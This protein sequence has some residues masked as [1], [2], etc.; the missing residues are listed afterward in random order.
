MRDRVATHLAVRRFAD[1]LRMPWHA[2]T[3]AVLA[4]DGRV[5]IEY[6]A[7]FDD[8][9]VIGVDEHAWRDTRNGDECV[10]VIIDITLTRSAHLLTRWARTNTVP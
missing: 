1:I 8:V 10:T 6:T 3:S 9:K 7:R 2:T 4:G 5:P